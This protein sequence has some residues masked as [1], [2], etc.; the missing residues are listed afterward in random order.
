MSFDI[1][2]SAPLMLVAVLAIG[3]AATAADLWLHVRV[4]EDGGESTVRVN[5]PMSMIEKAM[6]L[7]GRHAGHHE[8]TIVLDDLDVE[9]DDLRLVWNEL[10]AGPDMV[11]VRVDDHDEKVRV[12]KEDGFLLVD[13]EERRAGG[14]TVRARVPLGLVEVVLA[15]PDG[16]VD[17]QLVFD[18][19]RQM[20]GGDLVTVR[21]DDEFVRVWVDDV[22][23]AE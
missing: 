12:A 14:D 9:L 4:E 17:I 3:S 13:V 20:G 5:L 18:H 23:E 6:P 8:G 16:E 22:A 11:Y 1:K 10:M 19:L 15:S 7:I 2:K 21:G